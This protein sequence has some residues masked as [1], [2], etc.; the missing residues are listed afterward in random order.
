MALR[1]DQP[2]DRRRIAPG[3]NAL[4]SLKNCEMP[5]K[6]LFPGAAPSRTGV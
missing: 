4:N 2:L 6:F 3:R 5:Q 1:Y